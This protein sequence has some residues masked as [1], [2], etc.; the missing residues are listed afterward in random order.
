MRFISV[1]QAIKQFGI[2]RNSIYK[3]INSGKLTKYRLPGINKRTFIDTEQLGNLFM[4]EE[5]KDKS[6]G[7]D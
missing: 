2:S 1:K 3:L 4:P 6:N 7:Y 5:Y